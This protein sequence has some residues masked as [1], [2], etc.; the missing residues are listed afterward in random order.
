[1]SNALI[2]LDKQTLINLVADRDKT[3]SA[4]NR[5]ITFK[6]PERRE[7]KAYVAA[8]ITELLGGRDTLDF[9][10]KL[11]KARR[12]FWESYWKYFNVTSYYDTPMND[13]EIV[14]I[15]IDEWVLP[16]TQS[17]KK[18]SIAALTASNPE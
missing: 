14:F 18:G 5:L 8:R 2:H 4:L 1:M 7:I 10:S 11:R 9:K 6:A 12:W 3:I 13:Y 15:W 16:G 17:N